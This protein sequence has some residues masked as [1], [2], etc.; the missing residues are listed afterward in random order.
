[1]EYKTFL[2]LEKKLLAGSEDMYGIYQLKENE[3]TRKFIF[4]NS[5]WHVRHNVDIVR[6]NYE[7]LY[8]APLEDSM[9]L[10][11]LYMLF[12]L[13]DKPADFKGHS[14]SVSDVVVLSKGGNV[15]SH[16]VDSFGF[17]DVP[18]FADGE[19]AKEKISYY[20]ISDIDSW[21]NNSPNRAGLERFDNL[22]D[23]VLKYADYRYGT[24]APKQSIAAFGM[25]VNG[26]EFDLVYA[27]HSD[28]VLSLDFTYNDN[29]LNDE[30][31]KSKIRDICIELEVSKVRVHRKMKPDEIKDFTRNRFK[32]HLENTGCDDIAFYMDNFD[33]VYEKGNLDKYKPSESQKRIVEDVS[34]VE[35][36]Q[37]NPYFTFVEPDELAYSIDD[38]NM[39][40]GIHRCDDG[41]DFSVYD[42]DYSVIDG[43]VYDN[44]DIS[45]YSAFKN[46]SDDYLPE[47]RELK[48]IDY[49][50]FTEKVD[51]VEQAHMNNLHVVKD[52]KD[53][54]GE[55]FNN[56][57]GRD[58]S[59]IEADVWNYVSSKIKECKMDAI[60]VDA[61]ISGS[62]CRGLEN[63]SSD[64]DVVVEYIG[65]VREDDLFN[66][67]N[68]VENNG[69]YEFGGVKVDIN[70]I[71]ADQTGTLAEYLPQ[72]EKYLNEKKADLSIGESNS[73]LRRKGR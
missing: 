35:W 61:V 57:D 67:L 59:D 6:E 32:T 15:T 25:N 40:V 45:I 13:V 29:V 60:I 19:K 52:F 12:N 21:A 38:G 16:F 49:D 2:D 23:A 55:M 5:D 46:V 44:P 9:D 56:I 7:L 39:F 58:A 63:E 53:K 28:N 33:K 17:T 20:V 26:S 34:F 3:E 64:I 4:Q 42:S 11:D 51:L 70:P 66:I 1:M 65:D 14:M 48:P 27:E 36:N 73:T 37:D 30:S 50:D 10:E 22:S 69:P 31:F 54:T 62:R 24:D 43:G 72:V 68:D 47:T 18:N 8:V 71:T 41:Y